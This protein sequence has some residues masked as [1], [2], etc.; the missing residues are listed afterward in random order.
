[1]SSLV[2]CSFDAFSGSCAPAYSACWSSLA[3]LDTCVYSTAVTVA[4]EMESYTVSE[5]KGTLE[6]CVVVSGEK[7]I[8]FSVTLT[9]NNGT[10]KGGLLSVG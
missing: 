7:D 3:W 2:K 1:M 5:D 10:A 4:F 8:G 9:T 6:V